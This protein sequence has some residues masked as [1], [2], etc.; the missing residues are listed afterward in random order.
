MAGIKE[1]GNPILP[2]N[3]SE[4]FENGYL[5]SEHSLNFKIKCESVFVNWL[6]IFNSDCTLS[7]IANVNNVANTEFELKI[8][9][10]S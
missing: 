10:C 1:P 6:L 9:R 8:F 4:R 5:L 2:S 3:S 7:S